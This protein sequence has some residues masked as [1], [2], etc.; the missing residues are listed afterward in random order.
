MPVVQQLYDGLLAQLWAVHGQEHGQSCST[1]LCNSDISAAAAAMPVTPTYNNMLRQNSRI[2]P[3][4]SNWHQEQRGILIYSL[5]S[6][7]VVR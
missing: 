5:I 1:K 7:I 3:V 2:K 6:H 4:P